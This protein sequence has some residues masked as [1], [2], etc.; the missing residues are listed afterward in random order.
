MVKKCGVGTSGKVAIVQGV[1][2]AATSVYEIGPILNVLKQH[3]EIKVVSTQ[4]AD[5]DAIK[6]RALT[7]TVLQQ[8]PDLCGL[9]QLLGR[10]GDRKFR[11]PLGS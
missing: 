3:P 6:A 7:A 11:R 10:H 9:D 5:W 4:A 1:L 8:H 2:T